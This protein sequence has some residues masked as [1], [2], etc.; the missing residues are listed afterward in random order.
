MESF[1]FKTKRIYDPPSK[2]DGYRILI[3]RLWPRGMSK[4]N[5][6][7]NQW[8]KEVAPSNELRNWF[9][10]DPE[11]WV[12]FQKKYAEELR[13]KP[14]LLAELKRIEK[15]H[16]TVTLLFSAKETEHNNATALKALL[17]T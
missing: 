14:N 13:V 8:M 4:Q 3:D 7:L 10:H 6:Q 11:K 17:E 5:A 16:G 15:A 12:E 2:D 9:N 1:L